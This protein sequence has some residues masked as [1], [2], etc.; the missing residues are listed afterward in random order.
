[1]IGDYR[2]Y[3]LGYELIKIQNENGWFHGATSKIS[4]IFSKNEG[5]TLSYRKH[6]EES[7]IQ[8]DVTEETNGKYTDRIK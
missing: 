4:K 8:N 5:S 2:F 3:L 1:M 7:V 6:M